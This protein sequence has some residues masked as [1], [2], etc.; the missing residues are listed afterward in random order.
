MLEEHDKE[1]LESQHPKFFWLNHNIQA[2]TLQHGMDHHGKLHKR[3]CC[4]TIRL[5]WGL[6]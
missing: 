3:L 5:L 4:E 2:L 6:W 1:I